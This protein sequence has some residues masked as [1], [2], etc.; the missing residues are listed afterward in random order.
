MLIKLNNRDGIQ[1]NKTKL[2]I[3]KTFTRSFVCFSCLYQPEQVVL[4]VNTCTS[5]PL[6]KK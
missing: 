3:Y 6:K 5:F 2:D 1:Q 4:I